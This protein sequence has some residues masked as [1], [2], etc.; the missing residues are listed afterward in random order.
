MIKVH[1]EP[2]DEPP[3]ER[4]CFCR[5]PTPFW[6]QLENRTPGQQVACCEACA[7]R[8]HVQDVPTKAVWCRRERIAESPRVVDP[9]L[10]PPRSDEIGNNDFH[11]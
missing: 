2:D 11:R 10:G 7:S 4:C 3:F 5:K 9:P 8:A 6:T 1:K